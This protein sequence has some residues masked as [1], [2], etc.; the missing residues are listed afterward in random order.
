MQCT[1]VRDSLAKSLYERTFCWL[2]D[3][4]DTLLM[5]DAATEVL[6]GL[7]IAVLDIFGF[8]DFAINRFAAKSLD[9]N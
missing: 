4:I 6:P 3:R 7:S 9:N 5:P 1:S 2:V 8:E